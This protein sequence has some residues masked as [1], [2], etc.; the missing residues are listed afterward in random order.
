MAN[1]EK[2][3]QQPNAWIDRYVAE[4][5]RMLPAAQR[6]D[7]EMEMRSLIEEE[8]DA[9]SGPGG[10]GGDEIVLEVLRSFGPPQQMA[11]RYGAQ[12][13][14]I[15][16]A[17]YPAFLTVLRIVLA[18]MVALNVFALVVGFGVEQRRLDLLASLSDLFGGLVYGGGMVV[19]V[20][21]LIERFNR[22][23]LEK[24]VTA[25]EWDPRSLPEVEDRDRIK[26]GETVAEIAFTVAALI[27]LNFYLDQIGFYFGPDEDVQHFAIFSPEFRQYVPLLSLWWGLDLAL[28]VTLLARG[29]WTHWLRWA[30]LAIQGAGVLVLLR[31]LTGPDLA[32]WSLLEPAYRVSVAIIIVVTLLDAWKNILTLWSD[33]SRR[34]GAAPPLSVLQ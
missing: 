17:L 13:Y 2:Q 12:Q 25:G 8:V 21:A 7:V 29:R 5:G 30:D 18:V 26:I 14:L 23:A 11:A 34:N 3:T 32:A 22:A 4:V 9:R 33:R 10:S 1:L 27:A 31:M 24:A 6:A 16:P 28:K 15:G 20:F 19:L